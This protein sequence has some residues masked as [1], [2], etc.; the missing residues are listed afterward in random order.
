MN[1]KA[2]FQEIQKT[3][4]DKHIRHINLPRGH[5]H[6]RPPARGG[7]CRA[8]RCTASAPSPMQS[9]ESDVPPETRSSPHSKRTLWRERC[10]AGYHVVFKRT[11]SQACR[12]AG[13]CSAAMAGESSEPEVDRRIGRSTVDAPLTRRLLEHAESPCQ[14]HAGGGPIRLSVTQTGRQASWQGG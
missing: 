13:T 9:V 4:R 5:A 12:A 11:R 7:T 14:G 1:V 10:V 2:N 8:P 6:A 3:K